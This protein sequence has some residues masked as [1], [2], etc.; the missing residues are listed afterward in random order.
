MCTGKLGID[1]ARSLVNHGLSLNERHFDVGED[2]CVLGKSINTNHGTDCC[3]EVPNWKPYNADVHSCVRGQLHLAGYVAPT[4]SFIMTLMEQTT[5]FLTEIP[6]GITLATTAST[7]TTTGTPATTTPTTTTSTTTTPTTTTPTTTTTS[8]TLPTTI[9]CFSGFTLVNGVC[10]P[11]R[12]KK[13]TGDSNSQEGSF[14]QCPEGEDSVCMMCNN[15]FD[16]F[17]LSANVKCGSVT[18]SS[19]NFQFKSCQLPFEPKTVRISQ[20]LS[21]SAC[22]CDSSWTLN[23]AAIEVSAGCRATFEYCE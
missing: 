2:S 16:D 18:C 17:C 13:F 3:G 15:N 8:T 22:I 19:N 23:G 12:C 1:I 11:N 5:E 4:T 21:N 20:K 10:K 14:S 9:S 7:T 6:I